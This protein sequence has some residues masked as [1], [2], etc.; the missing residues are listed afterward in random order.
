MTIAAEQSDSRKYLRALTALMWLAVP[1]MAGLYAASW[2]ELP[3]RLATHFD[4]ANHPNGW[5]SRKASL[6]FALVMGI[7]FAGLATLILSRVKKPDP[8]AW[9]VLV[10]FYVITGTLLWAE[11]A[12][13]SYNIHGGPVNVTPVLAA[14]IGA[15]IFAVIIALG[16]RRGVPLPSGNVLTA[17]RHVSKM[18]ALVLGAATVAMIAVI[19]SIS[20]AGVRVALGITVLL[21]LASAATAWDGFHYVF[22]PSGIEIRTLGFRL[23][24]IPAADIKSYAIDRWNVMGGYGIRGVGDRRAYVWGNRGVLIK[25]IE[26]EIFLGHDSPEQIVRDL[27][28]ITRNHE[29]RIS[30]GS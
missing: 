28:L 20:V 23:R 25:T 3:A 22:S 16:T 17:E 19:F 4:L 12:V 15:A 27:D 1:V 9:A 5:M 26:G 21:M 11:D 8:A 30:H 10:L 18:L 14:G 7:F 24:S 6:T 29:V 2:P 13:I